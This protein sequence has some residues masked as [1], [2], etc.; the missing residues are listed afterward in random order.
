MLRSGV[1]PFYLTVDT[2]NPVWFLIKR[3][4]DILLRQNPRSIITNVQNLPKFVS[5]V[6]YNKK[7]ISIVGSLSISISFV[8]RVEESQRHFSGV[9]DQNAL[10]TWTRSTRITP[11]RYNSTKSARKKQGEECGGNSSSELIK[12]LF[13]RSTT[14]F[15]LEFCAVPAILRS[16]LAYWL[17]LLLP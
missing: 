17:K 1:K 16:F 9:G 13:L 12:A 6:D 7:S 15:L 8:R 11:H 4:A 3:T 2:G 14:I 5:N 10:L